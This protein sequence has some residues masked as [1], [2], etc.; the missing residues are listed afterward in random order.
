MIFGEEDEELIKNLYLIKG[1]GPRRLM[2]GFLEKDE[3]GPDCTLL[4][5]LH[6]MGTSTR[7]G[8]GRTRTVCND[9]RDQHKACVVVKG[10]HTEHLI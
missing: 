7:N 1:Y 5:R 4:A 3:N 9:L 10:G 2:S 8:S 6:K